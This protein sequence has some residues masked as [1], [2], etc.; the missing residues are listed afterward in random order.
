M[1]TSNGEELPRD[2]AF[3]STGSTSP[4][5]AQVSAVVFMSPLLP[6]TSCRSVPEMMLVNALYLL[7]EHVGDSF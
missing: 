2:I 7:R 4:S 6:E 5:P 1:T 3:P